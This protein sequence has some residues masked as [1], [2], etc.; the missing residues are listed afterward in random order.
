MLLAVKV[1]LKW[2]LMTKAGGKEVHLYILRDNGDPNLAFYKAMIL[3]PV[4]TSQW[5][6]VLV[7]NVGFSFRE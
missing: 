3:T 1:L 5:L 7:K 4:H 2:L 6:V